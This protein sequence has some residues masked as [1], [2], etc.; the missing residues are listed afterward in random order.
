M[1]IARAAV[2]SFANGFDAAVAVHADAVPADE[3]PFGVLL[4]FVAFPLGIGFE[5]R[6]CVLRQRS[7]VLV[8]LG[9]FAALDGVVAIVERQILQADAAR[10]FKRLNVLLGVPV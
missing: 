10:G 2:T 5:D 4:V 1:I 9:T 3:E 6:L 7:D 8:R